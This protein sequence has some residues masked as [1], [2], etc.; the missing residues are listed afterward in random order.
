MKN[1]YF[2]RE[3]QR[4]V[5]EKRILTRSL[6]AANK[7]RN[8]E[9]VIKNQKPQTL[10][11]IKNSSGKRFSDPRSKRTELEFRLYIEI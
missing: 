5:V 11:K 2:S 10:H 4:N 1:K 8:G 6:E 3:N 7:K 9:G